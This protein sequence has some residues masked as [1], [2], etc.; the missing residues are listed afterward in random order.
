MERGKRF[1]VFRVMEERDA[2]I[3]EEAAALW[4]E[5][6]GKPPPVRVGGPKLIEIITGSL[7]APDYERLRSPHLRPATIAGP[8]Q[9][10]DDSAV[11]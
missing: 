8:G 6:F 4:R 5:V 1:R 9:P 7:G 11:I 10:T 3:Y 2:R